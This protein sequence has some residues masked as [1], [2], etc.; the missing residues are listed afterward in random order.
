V[1]YARPGQGVL[2]SNS[3]TLIASLLDLSAPDPLG[4]SGFLALGWAV[5]TST[6]TAGLNVL[7]GGSQTT[8]GAG[9]L[10]IR[11]SF[12]P[13]SIP[14]HAADLS[15][16]SGSLTG[17]LTRLTADA[18][19]GMERVSCAL[20]AGRDTR[21]LAALAQ[22][23]GGDVLYYTAGSED[24]PDVLIAREIAQHLDLPHEVTGHEPASDTLDW[25]G[26]TASFM[27]QNDGLVSLLQLP[28][29]IDLGAHAP[30]LGVKLWGVGG[31]IGRAGTGPLASI[32]TN[33]PVL[34][35]SA[36]LQ[37]KLLGM[38]VRDEGALMTED[39]LHEIG[40]YMESFQ[41]ERLEEGWRPEQ[42]QEAFYTFERVARWGATGPR[43]TAGADDVFSPFCS[44]A[45]VNH[46]FSLR[47]GE[48][49]LE[50]VHYRLL[51]EL[52]PILRDQRFE[53]P[54]RTQRVWLAP[55]LASREL[56]QLVG[57][58]LPRPTLP[59]GRSSR[60]EPSINPEYPLQHAWLERHLALV[61]ELFAQSPSEL[62]MFIRRKR[63]EDLLDGAE[64]DRARHQEDLLRA[65]T[66]AWHFR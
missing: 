43:R 18:V 22:T 56:V 61:R 65:I 21:V 63:V 1:F 25:T 53:I 66:L 34:R 29:Y 12:G 48:R 26:A 62:W 16:S 5:A 49:Y 28:D 13:A 4:V 45:F 8:I 3:A 23:T 41:A 42:I 33:V 57:E 39:A 2:V 40:C 20:T 14:R 24:S 55:V 64:A 35:R 58:R 47:A 6:L 11:R 59:S 32:A 38:K 27:R 37:R 50:A 46:C 30:P 60:G 52:S 44:R 51:S 17:Y 9:S 10:R 54:F 31:E 7:P 15:L 36:R 19:R